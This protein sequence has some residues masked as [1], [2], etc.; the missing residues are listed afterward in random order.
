MFFGGGTPSL[1]SITQWN[2]IHD[3]LIR[4]LSLTDDYEWSIECN[5]DSFSREKAELWDSF[6]ATRLTFGVQSFNERELRVLGRAHTAVRAVE[7]MSDPVLARF[8]SI[9]V[10]LMYGLPGQTVAIT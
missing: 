10:D 6:G 8:S 1:L 7:V 9:G 3:R 4:R 5:P 2:K